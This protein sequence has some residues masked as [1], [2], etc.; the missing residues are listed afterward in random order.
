[1]TNYVTA[2]GCETDPISLSEMAAFALQTEAGL[3]SVSSVIPGLL[4]RDYVQLSSFAP[5]FTAGATGT[6]SYGLASTTQNPNGMFNIA[7]PTLVTLQSP[8]SY[9]ATLWGSVPSVGGLTSWR[10]A[11]LLSGVEVGWN[12]LIDFSGIGATFGVEATI[13]GASAG[14]TITTTG[15]A[16]GAGS[17][18]TFVTFV[19]CKIS[20]T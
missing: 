10:M 20:D 12:K 14:Q 7:T 15:L 8:G 1:M 18:T 13:V 3:S 16:T 4:K 11:I 19:V 6:F 2:G 5:S 9:V 17:G